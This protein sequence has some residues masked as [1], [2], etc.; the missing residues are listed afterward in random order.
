MKED[1]IFEANQTI[2]YFMG[3]TQHDLRIY[4]IGR[5]G[6]MGKLAFDESFDRLMP[7]IIKIEKINTGKNEEKY[8]FNIS[9]DGINITKF[10]DG[11]GIIAERANIIGQSKLQASFEVIASFCKQYLSK[12]I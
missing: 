2:A 8:C 12:T 7:V 1:E 4:I 9:A 6:N 10:D 11:T 3:W 5:N